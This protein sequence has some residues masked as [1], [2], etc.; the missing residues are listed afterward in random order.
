M[1]IDSIIIFVQDIER[2]KTQYI[3]GLELEVIEEDPGQWLLLS[4]G[5]MSL[6]LHRIGE[7]HIDSGENLKSL[8]NVKLVL[9]IESDINVKR[10]ELAGLG[11]MMQEVKSFPNY[12]FWICDGKDFEGN[13]IQLKQ[14]KR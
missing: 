13:V 8:K 1:K 4:D 3:K 6:G 10:R 14:S 12:D 9:R 11:F 2:L 7:D 5:K